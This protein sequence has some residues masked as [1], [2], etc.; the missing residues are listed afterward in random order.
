[1]LTVVEV[2]LHWGEVQP[3]YLFCLWWNL[4]LGGK[5]HLNNINLFQYAHFKTLSLTF[6]VQNFIKKTPKKHPCP[7][8]SI[9][10]FL[11]DRHNS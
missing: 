7:T 2:A 3:V 11:A 5:K 8:W 6:Q 10:S 1:M 4:N 9:T